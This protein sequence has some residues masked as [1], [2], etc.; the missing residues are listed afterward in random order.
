M[1]RH[2]AS[3]IGLFLLCSS[4]VFSQTPGSNGRDFQN[5][6][7]ANGKSFSNPGWGAN[8][9]Q[10]QSGI[11]APNNLFYESFDNIANGRNCADASSTPGCQ[12]TWTLSSGTAPTVTAM[13]NCASGASGNALFS[14]AAAFHH[15]TYGLWGPI[16]TGQAVVITIVFCATANGA[17]YD[18]LFQ[19]SNLNW[20][21][22]LA[23][24]SWDNSGAL[25]PDGCSSHTSNKVTLDAL[26]T[27]VITLS[28][29]DTA[30]SIALNG[31]TAVTFTSSDTNYNDS[32]EL[33]GDTSAKVYFQSIKITSTTVSGGGWLPTMLV[34]L[35]GASGGATATQSI[36]QAGT[37]G[38]SC[39]ARASM[40]WATPSTNYYTI[41]TGAPALAN[42]VPIAGV[43]Y[44]GNTGFFLQY[45]NA[46][47]TSGNPFECQYDVTGTTNELTLYFVPTVSAIAGLTQSDVFEIQ[48]AGA[49]IC[50]N[51]SVKNS[52]AGSDNSA[53]QLLLCGE[54]HTGNTA[55]CVG[56][57][58]GNGYVIDYFTQSSN[59]DYLYVYNAT[60]SGGG[61]VV[62][63]SE[64]SGS[65][66]TVT[67][68]WTAAPANLYLGPFGSENPTKTVTW[69]YSN[70]I[71]TQRDANPGYL[72]Q[73]F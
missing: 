41:Q 24:I 2:F 39:A 43:E 23:Q 17:N 25:C 42:P 51:T 61:R 12:N 37:H 34:D 64:V 26:N 63:G 32:V 9:L 71:L 52:C 27:L 6:S 55:G 56:I 30:S 16:K 28:T 46:G 73:Y 44:L 3:L 49:N 70:V 14:N 57:T 19:T 69:K 5:A 13:S 72:L 18:I 7:A 8:G 33:E 65:P 67:G 62:L 48:G 59:T 1:K 45:Q 4:V 15:Q 68:N 60:V 22:H 21:S 66:I 10:F 54:N 47:S 50:A 11:Y 36:L 40:Y 38:G 58:S 35:A 53:T 20:G 31:G 29:T